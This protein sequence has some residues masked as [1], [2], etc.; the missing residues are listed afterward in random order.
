LYSNVTLIR[1]NDWPELA[2]NR[3]PHVEFGVRM[4]LEIYPISITDLFYDIREVS[5]FA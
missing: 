5:I 3:S 1:E 4:V 2:R